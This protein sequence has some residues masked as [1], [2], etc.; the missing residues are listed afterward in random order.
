[1][2]R[3]VHQDHYST[4]ELGHQRA[5]HVGSVSVCLTRFQIYSRLV[6]SLSPNHNCCNLPATTDCTAEGAICTQD[7]RKL[8]NRL[9]ITVQGP[10]G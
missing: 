9:E 3:P 1:M 7:G 6:Y 8:S 5:V 2:L 4:P 10:A